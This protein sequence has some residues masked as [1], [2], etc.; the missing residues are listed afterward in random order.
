MIKSTIRVRLKRVDG[1]L[2]RL[3]GLM[4]RRGFEV[5]SM[6]A[7]RTDDGRW[8]DVTVELE[9]DRPVDVLGRQIGKL[10]DVVTVQVEP[11][12]APEPVRTA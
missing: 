7:R 3:L 8:I 11:A 5:A 12:P 6:V 1:S 4:G 10:F 2:L 9:S